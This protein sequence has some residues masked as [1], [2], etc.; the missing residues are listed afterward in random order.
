MDRCAQ[1]MDRLHAAPVDEDEGSSQEWEANRT[2]WTPS[3][4]FP[5]WQPGKSKGMREPFSA[6]FTS[7]EALWGA[8][9]PNNLFLQEIQPEAQGRA[10]N[11]CGQN[12]GE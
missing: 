5:A 4:R 11:R 12:A 9:P 3:V 1:R 10:G 6:C 7:A 8:S 2:R